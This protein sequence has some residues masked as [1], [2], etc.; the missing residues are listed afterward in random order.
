M[1]SRWLTVHWKNITWIP[2]L[3]R[4]PQHSLSQC[5]SSIDINIL[6]ILYCCHYINILCKPQSI[7]LTLLNP[8]VPLCH[9]LPLC[10]LRDVVPLMHLWLQNPF[11]GVLSHRATPEKKKNPCYF[12][13]KKNEISIQ[14]SQI[15]PPWLWTSPLT[16]ISWCFFNPIK[17]A[18]VVQS[19]VAGD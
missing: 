12:P 13:K 18:D 17:K 15:G 1:L 7:N 16:P 2:M 3:V 19:D 6:I 14:N 9:A 4:I 5:N 11:G 10:A 8:K